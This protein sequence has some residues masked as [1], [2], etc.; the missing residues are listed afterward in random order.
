[1]DM[2]GYEPTGSGS[3]WS[4]DYGIVLGVPGYTQIAYIRSGKDL[5]LQEPVGRS[6]P[7]TDEPIPF[8]N[9]YF[10]DS[11]RMKPSFTL[12]YGLGWALEMPRREDRE[13]GCGRG[14]EAIRS[15]TDR[16]PERAQKTRSTG[17]RFTTPPSGF[18]LDR[19]RGG[20]PQLHLSIPTTKA[21]SPHIA[22]AWNQ[23]SM[24]AVANIFGQG[25]GHPRRIQHS[26]PSRQNGWTWS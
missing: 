25:R 3:Q 11:W 13:A 19:Q 8:Y 18:N 7:P 15:S 20:P 22:V 23:G 17:A 26:L 16:P 24:R 5:N 6:P 10:S 9:L 21:F 4:R 12:S 14:R 1:M 2:T